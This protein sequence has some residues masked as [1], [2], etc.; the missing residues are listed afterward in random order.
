MS[1]GFFP[2]IATIALSVGVYY[3]WSVV[4]QK[5][6]TVGTVLGVITAVL[7]SAAFVSLKRKK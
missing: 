7:V 3:L 6:D 4:L 2:M 1:R 5:S